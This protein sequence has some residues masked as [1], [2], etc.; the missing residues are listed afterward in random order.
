MRVFSVLG[1]SNSGKTTLAR[2]LSGLDGGPVREFAVSDAVTLRAFDY[3]GDPWVSIDIAGGAD[4]MAYA[5]P[6]LA[7]SDMVVLCAPPETDSVVLS[8]PYLRLI[9][10]AGAPCL[11]FVNHMDTASER[12]R[13]IVAAYQAFCGHSIVLR[14]VPIRDGGEIVGSVDLISE[15]AWRYREGQPS[16]LVELPEDTIG[17]EQEARAELLEFLA[18]FDDGLL[19]QLI[20]DRRPAT[21]EVFDLAA[22]LV[23]HN[24]LVP[25]FLGSASHGN[26]VT[27]LMKSLRHEAPD[28]A[29]ARDRLTDDAGARA[30]G[31]L[32]DIRKHLGKLVV[33]RALAPGVKSGAE[34]AGGTIGGLVDLDV[35][36][37]VGELAP[38]Q[39]GVAVKSDQLA[40]GR[41]FTAGASEPLPSWTAGRPAGYRKIVAPAS[42]RDDARLSA[43]L[44]R[45]SEV[46]PG[47]TLEPDAATGRAIL[48]AQGPLH[49]R[50]L[51]EKLAEDFGVAIEE[52]PSPPDFRETVSRTVERRHRHRK[53]S[54][55]A[56]QFAEVLISLAPGP[57]GSG[58]AFAEEV[59]GGAVPRNYIPAIAAGAQEACRAGPNGFPVVDVAITLKDGKHHDVDSSDHAFRTAAISAMKE[60]L[61][62]A[63]PVV[64]Q[65]IARVAIH[66]PSQFSG[67]LVATVSGLKGQVLGFEANPDATG[68]DVF[69]ALMPE[70]ERDELFR[71][72]RGV[73]RGTAWFETGF[74]HYQEIGA[75]EARGLGAQ[76]GLEPA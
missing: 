30:V 67:A 46:D 64:L 17:R 22:R 21:E 55:G 65:P 19:E 38:G 26:G 18:D 73:T 54:G 57:R 50:R 8:A 59:K 72:L 62:A 11:L 29:A 52:R 34:L 58:L 31:F 13:D 42:E 47:L 74:D 9:A 45:L 2:A 51:T 25:A 3:L 15:R 33:I 41:L 7:A 68:W 70:A 6:A 49:A 12:V 40:S 23:G 16:A 75:V 71:T 4:A 5:G 63:G 27:R 28:C 60:A 61:E 39:V 37:P 32:A 10:E 69:T 43:A 66:V 1:P 14:Q 36:T 20:E 53:Q 56:G 48:G 76:K 35:K 24:D 44:G